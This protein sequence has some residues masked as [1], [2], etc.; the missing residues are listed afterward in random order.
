VAQTVAQNNVTI[1]PLGVLA[2]APFVP[3]AQPK[4]SVNA[5]LVHIIEGCAEENRNFA[6]V[7]QAARMTTNL[8]SRKSPVRWQC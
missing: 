3:K 7:L 2:V 5:D 8:S 1:S 6:R 4:Y